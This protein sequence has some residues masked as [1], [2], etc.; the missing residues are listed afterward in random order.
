MDSKIGNS[1]SPTIGMFWLVKDLLRSEA[2]CLREWLKVK[3]GTVIEHRLQYE[4]RHI[5]EMK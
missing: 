2:N 4:S 5:L 1:H 3:A